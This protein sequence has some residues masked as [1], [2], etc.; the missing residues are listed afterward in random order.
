MAENFEASMSKHT[1]GLNTALASLTAR[2]PFFTERWVRRSLGASGQAHDNF[3]NKV[4]WVWGGA[5]H[6][7]KVG[8]DSADVD[9][10]PF[11]HVTR[12]HE[13]LP[14]TMFPQHIPRKKYNT[15]STS[16]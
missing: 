1:P 4:W 8:A 9:R 12:M 6:R 11:E 5:E 2:M 14:T 3:D 15:R 10:R 13:V 16:S 7:A